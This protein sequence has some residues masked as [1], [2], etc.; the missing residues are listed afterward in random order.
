MDTPIRISFG[1]NKNI[2]VKKNRQ[3]LNVYLNDNVFEN[4]ELVKEKCKAIWLQWR[5]TIQLRDAIN[6]IE[7][8]LLNA[9]VSLF[10][11]LKWN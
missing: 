11:Y 7:E 10:I 9:K 3:Y 2:T 5:E 4:K 1:Y 6:S 8:Q